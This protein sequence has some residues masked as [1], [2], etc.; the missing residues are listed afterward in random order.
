MSLSEKDFEAIQQRTFNL[1]CPLMELVPVDKDSHNSYR[2]SGFISLGEK[3][4][5]Y[6]LYAD[7]AYRLKEFLPRSAKAGKLIE[8]L[9]YYVLHATDVSGRNWKSSNLL[10]HF[11]PGA[12]IVISG[13]VAEIKVS[14]QRAWSISKPLMRLWFLGDLELPFDK[15]TYS[16]TKVEGKTLTES[17]TSDSAIFECS[18]FN[19]FVRTSKGWSTIEVSKEVSK[20]PA[21][22]S[23][24]VEE[25]IEFMLSHP[26]RAVV[27]EV[28]GAE[29]M[30]TSIRELTEPITA[31]AMS[32]LK[33]SSSSYQNEAWRLFEC[34]FHFIE[35]HEPHVGAV[36]PPLSRI[37]RYIVQ[38][39]HSTIDAQALA[40]GVAVEGLLKEVYPNIAP[41]A[42][43]FLREIES[44]RALIEKAALSQST[45]S[46]IIGALGAMKE[47]RAK[48]R[49]LALVNAKV[50]TRAQYDAWNRLRNTSA[51]AEVHELNNEFLSLCWRVLVLAYCLMFNVIGYKGY[52][53]DYGTPGW[54]ERLYPFSGAEGDA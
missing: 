35:P 15:S 11:R 24:Q 47:S 2:G 26:A 43:E 1:D 20:L 40:L 6:K 27:V 18:G 34:F 21:T 8:D 51:H 53:T 39:N 41:P 16:E 54:P 48:D 44:A 28:F 37:L 36:R 22:L 4:L 10:P 5:K 19:F 50:I 46:R 25:S 12:G 42:E 17:W 30:E 32:P 33:R 13:S 23:Y 14:E 7:Q 29:G 52:Y 49:L 31:K 38:M 45:T 3:G 9:D